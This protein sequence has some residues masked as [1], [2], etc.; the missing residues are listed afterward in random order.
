MQRKLSVRVSIP[1]S[2]LIQLEKEGFASLHG[3]K[4]EPA[5]FIWH[6]ET[7]NSYFNSDSNKNVLVLIIQ[8]VNSM[9]KAL[10]WCPEEALWKSSTLLGDHVWSKSGGSLLISSCPFQPRQHWWPLPHGQEP[11]GSAAH[12]GAGQAWEPPAAISKKSSWLG[13][14]PLPF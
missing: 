1:F 2:S 6:S 14:R 13:A 5:T 8:W 4:K 12:S 9:L 11:A 10:K 7:R 3:W